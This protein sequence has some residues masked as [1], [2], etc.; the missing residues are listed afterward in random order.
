M[1]THPEKVLFPDCGVSKGQ[2]CAYYEAMASVM[3]PHMSGRPVTLERFP[4]GIGA[5]GF[6][7]KDVA[8]GFPEWLRRVEVQRREPRAGGDE[9][10]VHYALA[11]EARDLVWMANQNSITPHVWA[12][13]VPELDAPD[14]CLFDLDPAR[15]EPE[16]L[17]HAALAVRDLLGELGLE[18]F[19]KTSGSKGFHILAP[20]DRKTPFE[21]T[22]RFGLGVGAV[23]VRRFPELFTQEFIKADRQDRIL[24]DTGRNSRGA[25]FAAAYAVRARSGAPVSAPCT[26][27]EL[28][29]GAIGPQSITLQ[30]MPARLAE[31]GDP[32]TEMAARAQSL[33]PAERQ[34]QAMLNDDEWQEAMAATTRRPSSRRAKNAKRP[35]AKTPA[36]N[37]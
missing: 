35:R 33:G 19:V 12:S 4:N 36:G 11:F 9:S 29:A 16:A 31:L 20:L 13:R 28:E 21:G 26:W 10:P 22:W 34:L 30:T 15:D 8:K 6:I 18:S 5:K 14:C 2:L 25:T 24:I 32:W 27:T 37:S 17:R 7:Q 23:L 1:V 3:L